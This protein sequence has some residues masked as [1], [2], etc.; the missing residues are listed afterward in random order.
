VAVRT[1]I[2]SLTAAML[3]MAG[4]FLAANYLV[5]AVFGVAET[6][7]SLALLELIAIGIMYTVAKL[8][9]PDGVR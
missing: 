8:V 6:T 5:G 2:D 4:M 9:E 7:T 1:L 3:V